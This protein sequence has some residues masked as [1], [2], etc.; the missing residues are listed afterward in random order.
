M[1]EVRS[2][3]PLPAATREGF[4]KPSKYPFATME[5][6]DMFFV[7]AAKKSFSSLASAA[8]KRLGRKFST[9]AATEDGVEGIGCWR[10]E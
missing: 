8:G 10:V 9:R 4:S 5:V 7:P 3:I 1:F 6:G 2:G